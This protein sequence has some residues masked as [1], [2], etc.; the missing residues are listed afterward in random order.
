VRRSRRLALAAGV[1]VLVVAAAAGGQLLRSVP[2]VVVGPDLAAT[3]TVPGAAPSLPWSGSGQGAIYLKGTGWLGQ[4]AGQVPVAIAST[5]K[6]MTAEVVLSSHPLALGA[7]GP[8][9]TIA[10]ADVSLYQQEFAQD[11]SVVPVVA[12]ERLSELQLLEG[13]LLPSGDNLA[14]VLADWD[15]GSQSNFVALMNSRARGLGMSQTK[16]VDSS[17]LDPASVSTA[18]DL[19]RLA[20]V[21]MAQPVLA[22]IVA[23]KQA[24]LPVAGKVLNYD[25]VLGKEGIVGMKSGWTSSAGGCF[26]FAATRMVA[27]QTA[28]LVG[29]VVGQPG[30]A[31]TAIELA[32]KVSVGLLAASWPEL[33]VVQP[34]ALGQTLGQVSA[35]WQPVVTVRSMRSISVLGWPGLN[36]RLSFRAYPHR[37]PI[38]A[39]QEVVVVT[40]Q[41]KGGVAYADPGVTATRLDRAPLSWRLV[42]V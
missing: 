14:V 6:L 18:S 28:E 38:A 42:R 34:L 16:Y 37:P 10:A 39:G 41:T 31:T 4:T 2:R 22:S 9:V 33:Q 8:M 17:G 11:D 19:A 13:L 40:A 35:P 36:F 1:V 27:G 30:N 21:V 3:Y 7:S 23:M 12:G 24:V 29:A 25:F 32:Q 26:V 15:A 20:L 5:T